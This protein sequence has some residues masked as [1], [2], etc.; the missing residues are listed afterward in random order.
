MIK[1]GEKLG[2]TK[3]AQI[4]QVRFWQNKY[5]DSIKYGVLRDEWSYVEYQME[6]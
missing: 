3:E 2:F 4:R 6:N 5:W 1:L